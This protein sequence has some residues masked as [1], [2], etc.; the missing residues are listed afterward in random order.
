MMTLPVKEGNLMMAKADALDALIEK[1][2]INKET[3]INIGYTD[4]Y[5]EI[6]VKEWGI[7]NG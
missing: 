6:L 7:E 2:I 3:I 4:W 1:D 5:R